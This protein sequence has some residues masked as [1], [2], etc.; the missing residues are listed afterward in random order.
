M[1]DDFDVFKPK[2]QQSTDF[3]TNN[4]IINSRT[5]NTNHIDE[6]NKEYLTY[7]INSAYRDKVA[8]PTTHDFVITLRDP[9]RNIES[10][11]LSN[12]IANLQQKYLINSNNNSYIIDG[13]AVATIAEGDYDLNTIVS[14]PTTLIS[15]IDSIATIDATLDTINEKITI[16]SSGATN[17]LFPKTNNDSLAY[18]LG[19]EPDI[20]YTLP[21]T[22][23]Y[24]IN[25]TKSQTAILHINDFNI[26]YAN[27]QQNNNWSFAAFPINKDDAKYR[28]GNPIIKEFKFP[29]YITQIKVQLTDLYGNPFD[30]HNSDV[31]FDLI[32]GVI[33]QRN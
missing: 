11:Q 24:R 3:F 20:T 28:A 2:Q 33:N 23:P 21:I 9:I 13:G 1:D 7:T 22:A 12:F 15:T 8:Y 31:H 5:I 4:A 26:N 30:I 17:I 27:N 18:I 32:F 25:M 14:T 19:F 16:T 29:Q 10:I 6:Q